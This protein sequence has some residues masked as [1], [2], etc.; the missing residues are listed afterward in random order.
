ML[1]FQRVFELTN[2]VCSDAVCPSAVSASIE[3]YRA[4]LSMDVAHDRADREAGKRIGCPVLVLW[5]AQQARSYHPV[6]IWQR[7]ADEVR[8]VPLDCGHFVMDEAPEETVRALVQFVKE[9]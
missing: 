4:G 2:R 1:A 3:D 5:G 9:A 8:G 6:E 7:W